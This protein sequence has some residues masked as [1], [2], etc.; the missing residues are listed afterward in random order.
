MKRILIV[1]DEA[2]LAGL[3]KQVLGEE[4]YAARAVGEGRV[5]LK[6]ALAEEFDLLIVDWMLPDLDG[7]GLIRR[8]RAAEV[9]T[10]VLVLTA[11]DQVE[12]KVT[13]LD[14]GANDYMPKPFAL[15]ELLARVRAL[16]RK[17]ASMGADAIIEAGWLTL[18]PARHVV[19][20]SGECV[21][22][23]AKE[24]AL[25]A[26][27]MQHPGR[28]HTRSFL[29]DTIWGATEDVYT[30]VVDL[31][32]SHLRKKLGQERKPSCIRT[33]RGMGYAFD[34]Q[35]QIFRSITCSAASGFVSCLA[36]WAFLL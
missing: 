21:E 2:H 24:F 4:G 30:N 12:D 22:L 16:T 33:V 17:P 31:C 28:V 27:L 29:L 9:V 35:N 14:A 13:G 18:D 26:T 11:R 1:E 36:T 19:H 23:T 8:L 15:P 10:P 7:I 20:R 34:V 5:A 32:V 3:I 25:L 6:E